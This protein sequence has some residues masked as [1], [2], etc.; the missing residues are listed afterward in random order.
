M[1]LAS[2]VVIYIKNCPA[3][4]GWRYW[5]SYELR[6]IKMLRR[7]DRGNEDDWI[8][9]TYHHMYSINEIIEQ[10]DYDLFQIHYIEED[11]EDDRQYQE[12]R[13]WA[14]EHEHMDALFHEPHECNDLFDWD[15]LD[16]AHWWASA[17]GMVLNEKSWDFNGKCQSKWMLFQWQFMW[18]SLRNHWKSSKGIQPLMGS[19]I[20][21]GPVASAMITMSS[22]MAV[23]LSPMAS[24][25]LMRVITILIGVRL[26]KA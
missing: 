19:M 6:Q 10:L 24:L 2:G 17:N 7:L 1:G 9:R 15:Q 21:S 13:G 16:Q 26:G 12:E 25:A 22:W 4:Q 18:C 14:F 23:R 11:D 3:S 8:D 20:L 5:M